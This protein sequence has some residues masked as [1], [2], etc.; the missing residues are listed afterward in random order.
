MTAARAFL[1]KRERL[2]SLITLAAIP[3]AMAAAGECRDTVMA[4]TC[5]SIPSAA[6]YLI[7]S[8]CLRR[9]IR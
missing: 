7:G 4:T 2:G 3:E 5:G 6:A 9:T 1:L 8:S